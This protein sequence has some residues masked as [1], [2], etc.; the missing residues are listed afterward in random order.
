MTKLAKKLTKEVAAELETPEA[1][2]KRLDGTF[3]KYE[4]IVLMREELYKLQEQVTRM[5]ASGMNYETIV[6]LMHHHTKVPIK[7]IRK[8]LEGLREIP[9]RYFSKE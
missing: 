6:I 5:V 7:T 9:E 2:K 4:S 1:F 8:V 3:E